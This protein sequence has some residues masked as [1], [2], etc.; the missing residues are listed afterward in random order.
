MA[1]PAVDGKQDV[2]R[3]HAPE[4]GLLADLF[5]QAWHCHDESA[6]PRAWELFDTALIRRVGPGRPPEPI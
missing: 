4:D 2:Y 5:R 1:L 6:R 3:V